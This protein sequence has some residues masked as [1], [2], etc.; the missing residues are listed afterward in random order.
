MSAIEKRADA[1]RV[2]GELV[3][4]AEPIAGHGETVVE[5]AI[6]AESYEALI[7]LWTALQGREII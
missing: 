2:I 3:E 7:E 4:S 6:P 1:L 5:Y